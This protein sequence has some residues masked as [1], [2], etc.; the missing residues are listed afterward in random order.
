MVVRFIGCLHL[1]HK[2]IAVSRGFKDEF[3]HDEYL[4]KQWNKVVKP[5]DTVYILGDITMHT[6]KHYYKLDQLNGRKIVVLGNHDKFEHVPA[7]L[8]YVHAVAG[9]INYKGYMLTHIPIHPNEVHFCRGNIHAHIHEN[10]LEECVVK[11]AYD[12]VESEE[13]GTIN[14]YMNVDAFR[15]NFTPKTLAELFS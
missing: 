1:G 4:I 12:D 15:L 14:K 5:R 11:N 2:S 13:E 3:E 8:K 9:A 6:D 10:R 7:L